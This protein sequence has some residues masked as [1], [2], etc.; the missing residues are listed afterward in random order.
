MPTENEEAIRHLSTL[1]E[2]FKLAAH[3]ERVDA[4]C[5]LISDRARLGESLAGAESMQRYYFK[6]LSAARLVLVDLLEDYHP[7]SPGEDE[8]LE[9]LRKRARACVDAWEGK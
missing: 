9:S 2:F 7:H 4:L 1:T 8:E 5:W 3:N 6:Q